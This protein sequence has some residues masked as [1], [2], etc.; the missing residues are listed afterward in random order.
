MKVALYQIRSL[1]FTAGFIVEGDR[2]TKAAPIL[3]RFIGWT[4]LECQNSVKAHRWQ[5]YGPMFEGE[6]FED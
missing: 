1:Y 2:C 6:K 5:L 4:L 3:K